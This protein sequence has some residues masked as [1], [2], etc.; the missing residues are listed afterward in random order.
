MQKNTKQTDFKQVIQEDL[1]LPHDL[2]LERVIL[3]Q[4]LNGRITDTAEIISVL[5]TAE[6]FFNPAHRI[7]YEAIKT[8]YIKGQPI[9]LITVSYLLRE[10]NQIDQVGGAGALAEMAQNYSTHYREHCF[11]L[12]DLYAKRVL[13]QSAARAQAQILDC[14]PLT[15]IISDLQ[16]ALIDAQD[17]AGKKT[18]FDN[19]AVAEHIL[20]NMASIAKYGLD[21]D[22]TRIR[23][24][25]LR[26][27]LGCWHRGDLVIIAGRPAM[28]K[29][30]F[31][32]TIL[33]DFA[34]TGKAGIF[35]SLEMTAVQVGYRLLSGLTANDSRKYSVS[36]LK[37][38]AMYPTEEVAALVVPQ[39]NER[40]KSR[41]SND[42]GTLLYIDDQ[43]SMSI[44]QIRAKV[45]QII[46][47]SRNPV[48]G[49]VIDY[50][51][52]IDDSTPTN[53]NDN[54]VNR[55]GDITRAL[56]C[57]A[58]EFDIPVILLCQLSRAVETRS[59]KR[60]ILA[61]LRDSGAIEQ[62][63]DVV[64]FL[65]R[66][67]YYRDCTDMVEHATTGIQV[68]KDGYGEII[69]AKNRNGGLGIAPF[70]FIA[71]CTA[72]VDYSEQPTAA[73][74]NYYEVEQVPF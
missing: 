20:Q 71:H 35:L 52:L 34:L 31:V 17:P 41:Y 18:T 6:I 57:L 30:A 10:T 65:H 33:S 14:E 22:G 58:K 12:L 55:I 3:G 50:L 38:S 72:M 23:L 27:I 42:K 26:S 47:S 49:V 4:M 74:A 1:I 73:P 5:R 44:A 37:S 59:D 70:R 43:S 7:I 16:K 56:K 48:G 45:M 64:A 29:T 63:A 36:E 62:D 40:F 68:N 2:Q 13:I 46:S 28:G 15:G 24:H 39:L 9:D 51:G 11:V 32:E 66:P 21:G 69:V 60:P 61:D 67:E 8:L 25:E 54:K 53:R 19:I